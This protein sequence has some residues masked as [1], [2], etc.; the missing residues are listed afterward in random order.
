MKPEI[1]KAWLKA[2]R[3]GEYKQGRDRL[4]RRAG[5]KVTYCCLGVLAEVCGL[6]PHEVG[7][8]Q[9]LNDETRD[10]IGLSDGQQSD[11]ALMNDGRSSFEKIADYIEEYL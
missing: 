7:E 4:K 11:L 10:H 2:L 6:D 3:S 9:M 8:S 5:D 1:K